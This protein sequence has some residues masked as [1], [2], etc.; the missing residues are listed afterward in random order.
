MIIV[1]LKAMI[2][3]NRTI[4]NKK[5]IKINNMSGNKLVKISNLNMIIKNSQR[6]N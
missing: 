6:F 3:S 5:I 4:T 1:E 2:T